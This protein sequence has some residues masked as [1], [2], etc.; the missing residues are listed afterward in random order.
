MTKG[1]VS[2]PVQGIEDGKR[3]HSELML[4][5]RYI[6]QNRVSEYQSEAHL[7]PSRFEICCAR[8]DHLLD[9]CP[10][11][12][13]SGPIEFQGTLAPIIDIASCGFGVGLR[14]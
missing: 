11:W 1:V 8:R 7:Y 6:L 5:R 9:F 13:G 10:G 14:G 3:W 2:K 4:I 12:S